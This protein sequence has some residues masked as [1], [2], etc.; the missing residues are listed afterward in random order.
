MQ[1]E[2]VCLCCWVDCFAFILFVF[3]CLFVCVCLF[4]WFGVCV[5]LVPSFV[6]LLS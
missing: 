4:R 3:I 1:L 6:W 2:L 5:V